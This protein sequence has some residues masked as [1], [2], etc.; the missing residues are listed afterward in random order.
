MRSERNNF[1]GF[2]IFK[3]IFIKVNFMDKLKFSY[4]EKVC[5]SKYLCN[6]QASNKYEIT[7]SI[8]SIYT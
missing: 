1:E 2:M 5:L 8:Q 6:Q 4:V 7:I 3:K